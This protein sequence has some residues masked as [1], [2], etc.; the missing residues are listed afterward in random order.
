MKISKSWLERRCACADGVKWYSGYA[1][2]DTTDGLE[3]I[4]ALMAEDKFDWANWLIVRLME[5]KQYVAYAVYSAEQVV[6]IFESKY[7]NDNRPRLAIEAAKAVLAGDSAATR[8][9]ARAAADAAT[10]AADA[11]AYA[12]RES[13]QKK[14][15]SYGLK[16]LEKK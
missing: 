9:A 16:L 15:I 2:T 13:I 1:R 14:I 7:P 4:T 3:V 12:A 6:D 11:A 8:A 5:K 10:R